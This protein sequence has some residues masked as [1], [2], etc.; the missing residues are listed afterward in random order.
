MKTLCCGEG[1]RRSWWPL[2]ELVRYTRKSTYR[3]NPRLSASL[4]RRT[5]RRKRPSLKGDGSLTG[6]V[7]LWPATLDNHF[8]R[9]RTWAQE[10]GRPKVCLFTYDERLLAFRVGIPF[11][12]PVFF[13]AF[14]ATAPMKQKMPGIFWCRRFRG[15]D[16]SPYF[17]PE[18]SKAPHKQADEYWKH[19][20][21]TASSASAVVRLSFLLEANSLTT[22]D[23]RPNHLH[24]LRFD[25]FAATFLLNFLPI[26]RV[27][28]IFCAPLFP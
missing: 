24:S 4:G 28:F 22:D 7:R 20:L 11:C 25:L 10:E 19:F 14:V 18:G 1:R 23:T 21:P 9:Q 17:P 5:V 26:I 3:P 15:G 2:E 12:G 6:K 13:A 16:L 27:F 8:L